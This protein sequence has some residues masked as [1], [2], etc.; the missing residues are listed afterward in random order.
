MYTDT[1]VKTKYGEGYIYSVTTWL[2]E[3]ETLFDYKGL[4][5]YRLINPKFTKVTAA[6]GGK[7]TLT[8]NSVACQGYEVQ[9]ATYSDAKAGKWTKMPQTT[10]TNLTIS[11]L[12]KGTKYVFRIRCQKTNKDRGTTWSEYSPWGSVTVK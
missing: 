12:K 2:L 3:E 4:A 5:A 9:Y 10:K 6:G 8:W 1:S 11:G 7:V